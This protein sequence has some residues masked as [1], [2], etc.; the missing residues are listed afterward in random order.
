MGWI[1]THENHLKTDG[2]RV[3]VTVYETRP[4]ESCMD[5]LLVCSFN[6]NNVFMAATSACSYNHEAGGTQ[7]RQ[8]PLP[9]TGCPAHVVMTYTRDIQEVLHIRGLIEHNT[10]C[11]EAKYSCTPFRPLH[12]SVYAKTLHQLSEGATFD[13]IRAKKMNMFEGCAYTYVL[14]F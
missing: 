12:P 4:L 6:N 8:N 3:G 11:R 13:G 5:G 10:Q 14:S 1:R 7:V 9:I 2:I